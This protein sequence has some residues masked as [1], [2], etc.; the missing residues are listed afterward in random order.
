MSQQTMGK[1][2]SSF[3][4]TFKQTGQ[5][6]PVLNN[7]QREKIITENFI[8]YFITDFPVTDLK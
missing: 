3:R 8:A 1:S 7:L 2:D 4:Y 5:K 6:F